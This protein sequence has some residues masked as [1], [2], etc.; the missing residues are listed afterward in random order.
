MS[1]NCRGS[2][3]ESFWSWP[4]FWGSSASNLCIA[5]GNGSLDKKARLGRLSVYYL[6]LR[7]QLSDIVNWNGPV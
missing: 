4:S 2:H 1:L 6:E 3:C 7:G 5:A